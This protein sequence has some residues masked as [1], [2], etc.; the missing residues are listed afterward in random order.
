MAYQVTMANYKLTPDY[1][2]PSDYKVASD[3]L[4]Q[5]YLESD[6]SKREKIEALKEALAVLKAEVRAEE[7]T[8]ESYEERLQCF[9][10]QLL[11]LM[12]RLE[13]ATGALVPIRDLRRPTAGVDKSLFDDAIIKLAVDGLVNLHRHDWPASLTEEEKRG[14]VPDGRGGYFIGIVRRA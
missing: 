2:V 12:E 9:A 7:R 3:A 8:Y 10:N 1:K 6:A 5:R 11:G 14:M 4:L 13:P